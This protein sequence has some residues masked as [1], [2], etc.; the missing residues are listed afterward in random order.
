MSGTSCMSNFVIF[1]T[2]PAISTHAQLHRHRQALHEFQQKNDLDT[3]LQLWMSI[4]KKTIAELRSIASGLQKVCQ[5]IRKA[6]IVGGAASVAGGVMAAIGF[7]LIPVTFGGS[8]A[9]AIPGTVIGIAGTSYVGGA[10]AV[11]AYK[12]HCGKNKAN[13][14]TIVDCQLSEAINDLTA[15]IDATASQ[16]GMTANVNTTNVIIAAL[17][18]GQTLLNAGRVVAVKTVAYG[19]TISTAKVA[20]AIAGGVGSIVTVPIDIVPIG[21]S[22]YRLHHNRPAEIVKHIEEHILELEKELDKIP[23]EI[24]EVIKDKR[25]SE[26]ENK[27]KSN[28]EED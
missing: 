10:A 9:L 8:L 13:A 20:G 1:S 7:F 11:D 22:S 3:F 27:N 25:D 12:M 24:K 18:S 21:I 16:T 28:S 5:N 26:E 17:Y 14:A 19:A 4:R 2:L 6:R 15:A 23:R